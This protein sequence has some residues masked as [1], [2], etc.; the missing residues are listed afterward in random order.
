ME[1]EWVTATEIAKAHGLDPKRLRKALRKAK[2][3]NHAHNE[4]WRVA[5]GST[6]HVAMERVAVEQ[7]ARRPG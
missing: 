6:E 7:Q 4:R 5:R 3:F 1:N 2:P